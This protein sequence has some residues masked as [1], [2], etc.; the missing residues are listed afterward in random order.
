MLNSVLALVYLLFLLLPSLMLNGEFSC[1]LF[2][3]KKELQSL[4][5][6]NQCCS[7]I[8]N[9]VLN[10]FLTIAYYAISLSYGGCAIEHSIVGTILWTQFGVSTFNITAILSV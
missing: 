9:S 8:L 6:I 3:K 4:L 10:S 2:V 5:T 7:G 1:I